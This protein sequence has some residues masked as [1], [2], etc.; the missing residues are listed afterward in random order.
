MKVLIGIIPSSKENLLFT[1]EEGRCTLSACNE[2]DAAAAYGNYYLLKKRNFKI[3][4]EEICGP[5]VFLFRYGPVTAG[6]REAGVFNLYT[7][8]EKILRAG[9]D[10]SW[11]HRNIA[12]SMQGKLPEEAVSLAEHVCGN[13][14]FSHSVAFCHAVENAIGIQ[15]SQS[16][17]NWRI[18][19]LEAE[20]IYNH[21]YQ[22][23][24]LAAAA[25]Q[26][27][28]SAH[29]CALFEE[30]LRL[31]E[32]L[33]GSRYLMDINTIGGL[34]HYPDLSSVID[35]I[36][37]YHKLAGKFRRLYEHSLKN[38]NY[39][40]RLHLAGTLTPRQ[41]I[42][43]GLTGPSLRACGI[44]DDLNGTH[45]HLISLPVITQNE[46]DALARMEVRAEEVVNS[47]QYLIDH[48]K[49]SDTW[50]THEQ[51]HQLNNENA[52]GCA[53]ANSPSGAIGYYVSVQN[54]KIDQVNIFTPSYSG[55]HAVS[56]ALE[57]L[58]FTDFPFV[59]DSFGVHFAD[60]VV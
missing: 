59:F 22:I 58:V 55:M 4:N 33:T 17:Y 26:K 39:L 8:G 56:Q 27:V 49:V 52:E 19:L 40:D 47:C 41:A 45:Q 13:F 1:M 31:N 48:L 46:G 37:G 35:I 43:L 10:I 18:L 11:K 15:V 54:K 3:N 9:I 12:K 25:A 6:V 60:A 16:A 7:Y 20:R 44:K 24:K 29:L 50:Q 38:S 23:Y 57:G 34:N 21:I 36:K 2:Q 42:A 53:V 28:L 30:A 51:V 32:H 14:A 5:G